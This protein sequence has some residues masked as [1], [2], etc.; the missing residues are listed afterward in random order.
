LRPATAFVVSAAFVI[1]ACGDDT[2]EEQPTTVPETIPVPAA[3]PDDEPTPTIEPTVEPDTEPE[4]EAEIDPAGQPELV[5]RVDY[6]G[7]FAD[8]V[9][10]PNGE[11][12]AIAEDATYLHQLA[13]GE[14]IDAIVYTEISI[15]YP[16]QIAYGPDGTV[17]LTGLHAATGDIASV[18][19]DPA[20][21]LVTTF[22]G[23][24]QNRIA[25]TSELDVIA[26]ADRSGEIVLYDTVFDPAT[27]PPT[28]D[29]TQ[30]A[31]IPTPADL[32]DAGPVGTAVNEMR[33]TPDDELLVA[34]YVDSVARVYDAESLEL[35]STIELEGEIANRSL[36]AVSPDGALVAAAVRIDGDQM[37]RIW[38][39]EVLRDPTVAPAVEFEVIDRVRDLS[40]SPD[41]SLLAV[42]SRLGTTIWDVVA[43]EVA[44]TFDEEF[45]VTAT[46]QPLIVA[47]TPDGGHLLIARGTPVVELWRLPGAET[48]EA[49]ERI[50]CEPI[51]VP[52]DVLFDTGSAALRAEAGEVLADLAAEL[53]DTYGSESAVTLTF[54]GHTDSRGSAEA[55]QQLS[56]ER[57]R[58]VADYFEAWAADNG[59]TGWDVV[60]DGRGDTELKVIDVD[61]TGGFLA[62][63]GQLNR[64]VDIEIDA[65]ICT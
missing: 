13:D 52:G 30:R 19:T 44:H 31:R 7:R 22:D 62:G 48:L 16:E 39:A 18:V 15:G 49:P 57:A 60:T 61:A 64:R 33:F 3:I 23:G 20:G 6:E 4:G 26:T 29:S 37:I 27:E 32:A 36:I 59:V 24:F 9:M 56:A 21:E 17:L 42:A 34:Q 10:H 63:A 45:D 8:A 46:E 47:F 55:N 35:V 25:S 50:V 51:P 11:L 38:S 41:G 54:I 43:G 40:W 58:A 12:V 53:A 14:L 5:W 1:A 28:V 65:E 2:A